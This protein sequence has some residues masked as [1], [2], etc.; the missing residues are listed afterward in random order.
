MKCQYPGL[1]FFQFFKSFHMEINELYHNSLKIVNFLTNVQNVP[2]GTFYN[3]AEKRLLRNYKQM[4]I[5]RT[6]IGRVW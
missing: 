1:T 3:K 4:L 5:T 2:R 6:G